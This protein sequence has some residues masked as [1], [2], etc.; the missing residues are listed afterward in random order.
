[1]WRLSR[2]SLCPSAVRRSNWTRP[3][4]SPLNGPK[5]QDERRYLNCISR[6]SGSLEKL[7]HISVV[8]KFSSHIVFIWQWYVMN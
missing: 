4:P 2:K 5:Q 3:I 1:V 8:T 7:L 6:G